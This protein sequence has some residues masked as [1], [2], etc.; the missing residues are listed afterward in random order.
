MEACFTVCDD[1]M[2]KMAILAIFTVC[3]DENGPLYHGNVRFVPAKCHYTRARARGY[4][5]AFPYTN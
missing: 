2:A 1:E 5:V 3:D 4:T